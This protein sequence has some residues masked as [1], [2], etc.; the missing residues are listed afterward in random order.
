LG[1]PTSARPGYPV[2][3]PM[4]TSVI[5]PPVRHGSMAAAIQLRLPI[6]AF[7]LREVRDTRGMGRAECEGE[8]ESLHRQHVLF[9]GT[10]RIEGLHRTREQLSNDV[11]KLGAFPVRGTRNARVTLLVIGELHPDVVTDPIR[12]R[13]QNAA[14]P[15]DSAPVATTSA[16]SMTSVSAA[17]CEVSPGRASGRDL[18]ETTSSSSARRGRSSDQVRS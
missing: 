6:R 18:S 8:V 1:T 16:S 17:S 9:T 3:L 5:P 4:G 2:A 12:V 15:T 14:T 7:A 13:S 11:T 10:T